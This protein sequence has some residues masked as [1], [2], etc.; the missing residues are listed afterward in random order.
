L[1]SARQSARIPDEKLGLVRRP[2][3]HKVDA[4]AHAPAAATAPACEAELMA[5]Q[6]A[7]G[8]Q[9]RA[10]ALAEALLARSIIDD[11]FRQALEV[12]WQQAGPVCTN[13]G[14]VANTIHG[15]TH[16]GPVLQGR[17]F[18]NI[19]LGATQPVAPPVPP[20]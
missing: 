5:L 16:Y 9:R 8:D 4:S 18:G 20:S 12:W 14:H 17:D 6:Q 13:I 11:E 2:F 1:Q 10:I 15:G 19:T 3:R 7:P